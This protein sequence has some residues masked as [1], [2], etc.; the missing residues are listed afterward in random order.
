MQEQM[1]VHDDL[2]HRARGPGLQVNVEIRPTD[3]RR[4]GTSPAGNWP[5]ICGG[6]VGDGDEML[7]GGHHHAEQLPQV[8]HF[9][10]PSVVEDD[11]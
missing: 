4:P 9:D 7:H 11:P 10:D 8:Q 6:W 5:M 3:P 1:H 2:P